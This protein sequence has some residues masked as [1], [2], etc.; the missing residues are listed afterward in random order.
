M[1]PGG[2]SSRESKGGDVTEPTMDFE[3]ETVSHGQLST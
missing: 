1:S 2:L 3:N